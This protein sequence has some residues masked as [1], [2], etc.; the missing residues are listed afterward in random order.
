LNKW[1]KNSREYFK[2][3]TTKPLEEQNLS[4]EAKAII[5]NIFKKYWATEY[6]KERIEAKEKYDI[7][8]L[9]K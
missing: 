2:I 5:A 4:N 6:Q 3:D 7:E 1:L 9:E 8:Q